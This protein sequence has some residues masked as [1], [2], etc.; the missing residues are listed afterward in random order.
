MPKKLSGWSLPT[1]SISVWYAHHESAAT[2]PQHSCN[3]VATQLSCKYLF[4]RVIC[5][6]FATDLQ[7]SCSRVAPRHSLQLT[8]HPAAC[9]TRANQR[10][11]LQLTSPNS[12]LQ[13]TNWQFFSADLENQ[14][15]FAKKR[16][17]A[18]A[19]YSALSV[20]RRPPSGS[21]AFETLSADSCQYLSDSK[22]FPGPPPRPQTPAQNTVRAPLGHP[23]SPKWRPRGV[24]RACTHLSPWE[25]P[26]MDLFQRSLSERS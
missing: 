12:C 8:T 16:Q 24:V 19:N 26:W 10:N 17:Y 15:S 13:P 23:K 6:C 5:S 1:D 22:R 4:I 11:S 20:I 14:F 9:E 7:K 2:Q 21:G 3:S 25:D 18:S